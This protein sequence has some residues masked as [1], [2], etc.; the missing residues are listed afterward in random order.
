M[1][2]KVKLG[3]AKKLLVMILP[4]AAIV[5][6][7]IVFYYHTRVKEVLIDN[8][9]TIVEAESKNHTKE[10]QLQVN[11]ILDQVNVMRDALETLNPDEAGSNKYM[12]DSVDY[13]KFYL[14]F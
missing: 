2:K 14:T 4:V 1:K 10:V 11:Q 3:I 8:G 9:R 6:A 12:A 5:M 7:G 13:N